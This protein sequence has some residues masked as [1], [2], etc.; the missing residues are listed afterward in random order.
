M[1]LDDDLAMLF[2]LP[3]PADSFSS[4]LVSFALD[5]AVTASADFAHTQVTAGETT[6]MV[7]VEEED[8]EE[9]LPDQNKLALPELQGGHGLSP[10]SKR[11]V[12]AVLADLAAGLNPTATTLRLRR[13]AFWGRVRV[14]ILA[15]TIATVA[16][17]DLILAIA[18][19]S[20]RR[21]RYHYDGVP[22][23]T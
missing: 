11:L 6:E 2:E 19:F 20:H 3:D 14:A 18:L 7:E 22:P 10:R 9:P 21:G 16:A 5:D 4:T 15:V 8:E 1:R 23:P 17:I 12:S 13:A